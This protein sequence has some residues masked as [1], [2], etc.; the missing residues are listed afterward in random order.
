MEE[1]PTRDHNILGLVST[2][3][4]FQNA[5]EGLPVL[6]SIEQLPAL[7][8]EYE[9]DEVFFASETMSHQDIL[10]VIACCREV[11]TSYKIVSDMFEVLTSK[12][13]DVEEIDDVPVIDLG[14]GQSGA[15]YRFLKRA[16]DLLGV[17]IIGPFAALIILGIASY[18]KIRWPAYPVLFRHERVGNNGRHFMVYKLRTMDPKADLYAQAPTDPDDERISGRFGRFLR[19]SSLDE[20]P[21]LWNVLRG[22]MSLVGP[23]PEMPFIVERYQPWQLHRLAVKPGITGLWQIMGRKDLPLYANL[24][25]DFYYIQN[26][27]ILFDLIIL[28]KTVPVVLF[29]KGAY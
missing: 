15:G 24:E 16:M 5:L 26:Q 2:G 8:R 22:E 12:R 9:V 18:L 25:Y 3:E 4:V 10:N 28:L 6:G 17:L 20:L 27:S 19:R 29:G 13:V 7:V 14:S 23:R 1:H 11:K 21:Q